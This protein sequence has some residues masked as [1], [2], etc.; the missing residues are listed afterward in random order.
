MALALG[1][2]T[3]RIASC[4]TGEAT[5]LH[6]VS[7]ARKE[8]HALNSNI[9]PETIWVFCLVFYVVVG[10]VTTERVKPALRI[11]S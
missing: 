4:I 1:R 7:V 10:F 9:D 3:S 6:A 2:K 8:L 5:A 11:P